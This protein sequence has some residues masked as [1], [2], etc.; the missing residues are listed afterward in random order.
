MGKDRLEPIEGEL[1]PIESEL[2][3]VDEGRLGLVEE[4]K[5][6]LLDPEPLPSTG[7]VATERVLENWNVDPSSDISVPDVVTASPIPKG[8]DSAQYVD[9]SIASPWARRMM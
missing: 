2:E 1:E 6:V 7:V 8:A 3:P 5:L 4:G 9:S